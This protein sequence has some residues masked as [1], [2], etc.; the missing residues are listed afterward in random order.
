MPVGNALLRH[1]GVDRGGTRADQHGKA[2]HIEALRH[3]G[4]EAGEGAQRG[5]DQMG[6]HAAHGQDHRNGRALGPLIL[7]GQN[8]MH[9]A[10]AHPLLR[11]AP[12]ALNGPAQALLALGHGEG[13][14]HLAGAGRH[15]AAHGVELRGAQ[16]RAVQHQHVALLGVLVEDIAE[17][18]QAGAQRH[19]PR[20]AQA[21][22]GRVG[23]LAEHLP[24]IMVQA[25]VMLAQHGNRRVIAHAA[26]RLGAILHHGVQNGLQLLHR[27]ADGQ[28]PPP[29]PLAGIERGLR[30]VVTD[31]LI[32]ARG[33]LNPFAKR[34][35]G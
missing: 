22:D 4:I 31:N 33:A 35:A 28:L 11:L 23:H 20:L 12:N 15:I 17:I 18:A 5:L 6:V 3:P 7:I 16:H 26:N 34:L 30:L 8:H 14:I 29:Q 10:R 27:G 24:E 2:M 32:N 25:T 19:H 9:G 1:I 21:V 13:A